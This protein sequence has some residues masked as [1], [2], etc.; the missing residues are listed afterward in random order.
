MPFLLGVP[1]IILNVLDGGDG[2][3]RVRCTTPTDLFLPSSNHHLPLRPP[4]L[5]FFQLPQCAAVT[6]WSKWIYYMAMRV[7]LAPVIRKIKQ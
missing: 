3:A 1:P 7:G 5:L 2:E 6:S 4:R